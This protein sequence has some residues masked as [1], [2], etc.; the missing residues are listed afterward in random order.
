MFR[1]KY[2]A[3]SVLACFA[4][5]F[6]AGCH[7]S[8]NR[9]DDEIYVGTIAG[10]E[11]DLM[12]VAQDVAKQKYHL[13]IKIITFEDYNTP[14][15]ALADGAID[16]NMFQHQPYLDYVVENKHY[17]I[18]SI[19]KTF[20]YPMGIYSHKYKSL[21]TVPVGAIVAIPN[22]PSN[23]ARALRLLNTAG[24]IQLG[25]KSGAH[26][27]NDVQLTIKD[28]SD[29]PKKLVLKELDAAQLPRALDDVDIA[30]INTNF[31]I[32]AGLKPKKDAIFLETK[33]SPY[34]NVVVVR[35]SEKDLPKFKHLM[36]ALNSKE[37]LDKADHLF[38][39]QAIAAWK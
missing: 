37:V 22:D 27:K 26:S 20:I 7:Q 8:K 36:E 4:I 3:I 38:D 25:D 13:N 5:L 6:T 17:P 1:I 9:G 16:A 35:T 32:P 2:Y 28:I 29:N 19:G 12:K 15:T 24:L 21:E 14:N 23:G 11:T 30:V 39:G 34:A 18:M 10:P 31:A 33:D